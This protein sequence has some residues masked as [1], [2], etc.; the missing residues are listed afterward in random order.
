VGTNS[1]IKDKKDVF[2]MKRT[3][4]ETYDQTKAADLATFVTHPFAQSNEIDPVSKIYQTFQATKSSPAVAIFYFFAIMSHWNLLKGVTYKIPKDYRIHHPNLWLMTLA[5]SGAS[6]SQQLALLDGLI[7]DEELRSSFRQPASSAS[8]INQFVDKPIHLWVEDEAA[9]YLK[10][11]ETPTN[12]LSS[13]KGHLLKVKGGDKLTYHS[14]KDGEI[15]V[16]NPRMSIYLVNTI[17]GM[18]N[19]IS[20]ESMYDGFLSRIGMVLSETPEQMQLDI[21]ANYPERVHDL[22]GIEESGLRQDLEALFEQDI[23]GNQYTFD[24]GALATFE[25]AARRMDRTFGWMALG[26][27]N[28]YKPFYDRTLME[29][30]KYAIFHHQMMNKEGTEIDAF[31]IEYGMLVARYHLCSFA[32]YLQLRTARKERVLVE[33]EKRLEVK[34]QSLGVRMKARIDKNPEITLREL[35]KGLKISKAKALEVL[36]EIG[37]DK[38]FLI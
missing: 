29:A 10:Q 17:V 1:F 18:I 28:I 7:P 34:E 22:S 12:P 35:Y 3:F 20:E 21:E 36:E 4:L 27:E 8:F 15:V 6:K 33:V 31:D 25:D 32:R 24:K 37:Y 16:Q 13:I 30:F 23:Q 5:H 19:T 9:K 38:R 14:K 11:I 2:Q 26:E